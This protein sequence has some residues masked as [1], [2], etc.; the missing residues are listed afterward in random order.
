MSIAVRQYPWTLTLRSSASMSIYIAQDKFSS[1]FHDIDLKDYFSFI[2]TKSLHKKI[3]HHTANHHILPKW[4]FPE[5]SNFRQNTWNCAILTHKDH[6]IAHVI[7][8]TI[9]PKFGNLNTIRRMSNNT[10]YYTEE[11]FK[12]YQQL[13]E[14]NN[15]EIGRNNSKIQRNLIVQGIHQFQTETHRNVIRINEKEKYENGTANLHPNQ[16]KKKYGVENIMQI[17]H[18]VETVMQSKKATLLER[19]GVT[20]NFNIPGEREKHIEKAKLNCL[21]KHG[22]EHYSQTEK[23]REQRKQQFSKNNPMSKEETKIKQ[24]E[25]MLKSYGVAHAAQNPQKM[26]QIIE[27]RMKN[28][29]NKP[30]KIWIFN[31]DLLMSTVIREPEFELF[32]QFGFSKGRKIKGYTDISDELLTKIENRG[33]IS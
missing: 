8:A 5:Y 26:K 23:G 14:L 1:K 11:D 24:R 19:Y 20:H 13:L 31:E 12:E 25:S 15:K 28:E 17:P 32:S 22:V 7:L 21:V 10:Q 16:I 18:I 6:L 2:E 9:W 4:A 3:K 30:A 33:C 29:K 27:T